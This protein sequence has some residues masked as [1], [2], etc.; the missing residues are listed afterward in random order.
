MPPMQYLG[1]SFKFVSYSVDSDG[2]CV[3]NEGPDPSNSQR[4]ILEKKLK[5]LIQDIHLDVR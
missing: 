5:S 3:V 2:Q 4:V 1:F